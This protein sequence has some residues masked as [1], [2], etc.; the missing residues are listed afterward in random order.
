MVLMQT[1]LRG[2]ER[3]HYNPPAIDD[4][5]SRKVFGLYLENI[6]GAKR[7]FTQPDIDK[8][9]VYETA[10]DDQAQAGDFTFFNLSQELLRAS[11]QKTQG[12]YREILAKPFDFSKQESVELDGEKREWAKNDA[13]L[14]DYWAR[15]LKYEAL[16]RYVEALQTQEKST[17]A[18]VEKKTPAQLEQEARED[19]LDMFDR[20][21][22]R[23]FKLKRD[24]RMSQY[25]NAIT[26][27]Y[28]P[29]TNYFKPIDKEN[30][31]IRFS[32]RLE[33]IGARLMTE[34][35]YTKVTEV[36][37]GGPA[38]KGKELE[39]NDIILKVAQA[40]EEPVDIKGMLI[41]DV[42]QMVRGAKGTEVRLTIKKGD[43]AVKVISIIRDVV[44]FDE[45]FAKSL[46]LE[47]ANPGEKVGYLYLPSF[48]A[49]FENPNG[50]NCAE[51][52]AAELDKLK[53]QGVDGI[54]LDLRNNGGG[55]LRDVVKMS[56]Y[57]VERGPI[58]QVKARNQEPEVLSDVDP[59]VQYDGPVVVL[60]NNFSASASEI[61]AAALQ[62]YGRAVIVGSNSS[63][64]K[65]TVQR[66]VDL[67]RV[68]SPAFTDV[69]P[70][71]EIKLTTQKF[72]RING[73]STQL[74]GVTPDIVLPDNYHYITAGEKEEAYAMSWTEIKPVP[75]SQNV[76][77]L[78]HLDEVK[79][80]SQE[81]MRTSSV[82]QQVDANAR[83]FERQSK[84]SSYPLAQSEFTTLQERIETEAKAFE[85]MFEQMVNPGVV[86]IPSDL[87]G[88]EG[89]ESKLARNKD[90]ID[91]TS[92]DVYIR[93]AIMILH[94]II[95]L[96]R[97]AT[98]N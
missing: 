61:L 91:V 94:D 19:V 30:F 11:M 71:G 74:L 6:D 20:W 44:I 56:G 57:F 8:M 84:F 15:Y 2:L 1:V 66:F 88:M 17:D 98:R 69:K 16:T 36:V 93:E 13:E 26:G 65:G 82:F 67:D 68:V 48:Y 55:S 54:I 42:V 81:R 27:I 38:W 21:Y 34:G 32:G 63:F 83:R 90:F 92:K 25:I 40:D 97:L 49:D 89:D 41:D 43:G 60:V 59:R 58:V 72:Y 24:D 46:I 45:R 76:L 51:D 28:D 85:N 50:R 33:G 86:N 35:D 23:L 87:P 62:D 96:E 4:A 70:L 39:E 75:Y 12:Y 47:G 10:L 5:F 3:Y 14:R 77:R 9:V 73:G 95:D 64:G 53:A 80:R 78:T 31:D 22:D 7:F 79:R 29:H 18:T 37:V 52:V